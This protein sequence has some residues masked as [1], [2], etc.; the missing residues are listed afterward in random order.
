MAGAR[1]RTVVVTGGATGIGKAVAASFAR[2]G[3]RVII[4]GRR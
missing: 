1:G 2:D 3:E 4:M